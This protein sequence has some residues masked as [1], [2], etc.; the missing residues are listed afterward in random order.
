MPMESE[1]PMIS[2]DEP[3]FNSRKVKPKSDYTLGV[4]NKDAAQ[5]LIKKRKMIDEDDNKK[6]FRSGSVFNPGNTGL[7][8]LKHQDSYNKIQNIGQALQRRS[9]ARN[10]KNTVVEDETSNVHMLEREKTFETVGDSQI[11]MRVKGKV[12]NKGSIVGQSSG[13]AKNK[14]E[15]NGWD[16]EDVENDE[17]I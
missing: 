13:F 2:N 8:P 9:T 6:P 3:E 5:N 17:E 16:V 12:Q 1:R 4:S 15:E 7:E 10:L 14:N 11:D